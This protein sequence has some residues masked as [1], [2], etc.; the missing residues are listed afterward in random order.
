MVLKTVGTEIHSYMKYLCVLIP[1][2]YNDYE[3][4]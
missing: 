1:E 3:E 2:K 4:F